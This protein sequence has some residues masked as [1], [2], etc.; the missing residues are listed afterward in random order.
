MSDSTRTRAIALVG[1]LD[2]GRRAVH[3]TG[4]PMDPAKMLP[5]AD[6]VLL[7][8]SHASDDPGAML[9]RYTAF[10]EVGGDTWHVSIA[11]AREQA[12]EEYGD[13]L[14]PWEEV[15]DDVADAHEFAVRYAAERLKGR[16]GS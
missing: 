7:T 14:G 5:E 13:A 15:P 4:F 2:G 9:F 8:A 11:D 10:G 6:V 16:D 3:T 12:V 1:A